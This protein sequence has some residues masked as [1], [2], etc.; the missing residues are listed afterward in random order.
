MRVAIITPAFVF[1]RSGYSLTGI[2]TYQ[3][4]MLE[5]YGHD[6]EVWVSDGYPDHEPVPEG[7]KIK[8]LIPFSNLIDYNRQYDFFNPQPVHEGFINNPTTGEVIPDP[9]HQETAKLFSERL[10]ENLD[11]IDI[12]FT[13]DM[14]FT[15]WQL[16]YCMGMQWAC[17][18]GK[19]GH[20]RW[21]HW[22]HSIPTAG[23]GWWD[24]EKWGR[25]HKIIYP[26]RCERQRVAEIYRGRWEDVRIIPHIRDMRVIHRFVPGTI[27]FLDRHPYVMNADVLQVYPVGTDRL[28]AKGVHKLILLFKYFKKLGLDVCLIL[29]NSWATQRC[30]KEE[31]E[32]YIDTAR[33][34]GL[35]A[36]E[37][38]FTS[39][40]KPEYEIGLPYEMVIDLMTLSNLFV[41]PTREESFGLVLPEAILSGCVIPAINVDVPVLAEMLGGRGMQFHFGSYDKVFTVDKEAEYYEAMAAVIYQR[42][43]DEEGVYARTHI[44]QTLNLDTVYLKYYRPIM[45]EAMTVW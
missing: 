3:V 26:G 44:R 16:P 17:E 7:I 22:I 45:L 1:F 34:N 6:V 28:E 40:E 9:K 31:I 12:V 8:K 41:F 2:I 32:D 24:I 10:V 14:I 33:N 23:F 18:T 5:K 43:L 29:A 37:V 30:N 13:H 11:D 42:M 38:I 36:A 4:R 15:G 20:I 21:M 35:T 19:L 25:F 27:E 39:E